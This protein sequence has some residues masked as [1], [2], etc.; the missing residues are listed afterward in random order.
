M[1]E[2]S[3]T[4]MLMKKL[5]ELVPAM[6]NQIDQLMAQNLIEAWDETGVLGEWDYNIAEALV[7]IAL[8]NHDDT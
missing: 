8:E 5:E 2:F 7:M 3:A 1:S 4:D 6:L